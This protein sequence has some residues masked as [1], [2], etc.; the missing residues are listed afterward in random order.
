[1]AALRR[2]VC[3]VALSVSCGAALAVFY[4]C[5]VLE[6]QAVRGGLDPVDQSDREEYEMLAQLEEHPLDPMRAPSDDLRMIPGFPDDLVERIS[7]LRTG[8][9]ST[10]ALLRRLTPPEREELYRFEPYLAL[11]RRRPVRWLTRY[12]VERLVSPN[13]SLWDFRTDFRTDRLRILAR[14][15]PEGVLRFYVS[16][17]CGRS[18]LRLHGGDFAP[19]LGSGLVA[20]SYHTTYPFSSGYH[21]HQCRWVAGT[22]SFYGPSLRGGAVEAWAGNAHLLIFRGREC[23]YRNGRLSAD[24]DYV[25]GARVEIGSVDAA[26]GVSF[27][28]GRRLPEGR[29]VSVDLRLDR[30]SVR[31][32]GE[33]ALFGGNAVEGICAARVRTPE[34]EMKLMILGSGLYS[35]SRY[36]RSFHGRSGPKRGLSVVVGREFPARLELLSAFERWSAWDGR[37]AESGELMRAELRRLGGISGTRITFSWRRDVRCDLMPFPPEGAAA[38]GVTRSA[39]LLQSIRLCRTARL[40]LSVRVPIGVDRGVMIAPSIWL[41]R[42]FKAAVSCAWHSAYRGK[43]VFYCYEP[44][45]DGYY[46]WS[47]LRGNGWRI[48]ATSVLSARVVSIAVGFSYG[49]TGEREGTVQCALKL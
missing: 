18:H 6:R 27:C 7:D 11:P 42:P 38:F 25:S 23:S 47:A 3:G 10:S 48:S 17:A 33:L 35:A 5:G 24:G 4:S 26:A 32:Q 31:L 20:S 15:R 45:V 21:A 43:P 1:M 30:S 16:G 41:D 39:G 9:K 14:A 37:R 49:H 29:A 22:S 19:D 34:T 36:G 13:E 2:S 8:T 40:R 44:T 46:P 28:V 12:T